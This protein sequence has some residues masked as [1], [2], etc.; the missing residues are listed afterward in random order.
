LEYTSSSDRNDKENYKMLAGF[1]CSPNVKYL[2]DEKDQTKE[3][4]IIDAGKKIINTIS[5]AWEYYFN[6]IK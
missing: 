3:E 2:L 6:L 1:L 5:Y 4:A